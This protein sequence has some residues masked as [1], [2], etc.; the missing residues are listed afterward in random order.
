MQFEPIPESASLKQD[1]HSGSRHGRDLF[2]WRILK[3][4][5]AKGNSACALRKGKINAGKAGLHRPLDLQYRHGPR[6]RNRRPRHEAQEALAIGKA[7][8]QTRAI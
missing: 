2:G 4:Y 8:Q 1:C 3:L 7:A 5:R 6:Q